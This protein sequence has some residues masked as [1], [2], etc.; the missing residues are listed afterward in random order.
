MAKLDGTK[1]VVIGGA[2]GV[3]LAVAAAALEAGAQ[4]VVGSSQAHRIAA[5][6]ETLGAGAQGHTVDVK[7]EASVAAFFEAAGPFD[8]PLRQAPA[9]GE[10]PRDRPRQTHPHDD[11]GDGAHGGHD[12]D[13]ADLFAPCALPLGH[14]LQPRAGRVHRPDQP[15]PKRDPFKR[16]PMPRLDADSGVDQLVGEDRGDLRRH[17]VGR[18]G[19]VRPDEDFKVAVRAAPVIPALADRPAPAAGAGEADGHPHPVGEGGAQR[20]EQRRH[21]GRHPVQ[22]AL[23]IVVD[24]L[25][26][27]F[28]SPQGDGLGH[29]PCRRGEQPGAR[30]AAGI[31]RGGAGAGRAAT[32]PRPGGLPLRGR[33][34]GAPL[35][36]PR[37]RSSPA[38]P[39]ASCGP[40]ARPR[41]R[42]SPDRD[43]TP[44]AARSERSGDRARS[45]RDAPRSSPQ[46][47]TIDNY[48]NAYI[49]RL[50]PNHLSP[51]VF[52][53]ILTMCWRPSQSRRGVARASPSTGCKSDGTLTTG[54][55]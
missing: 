33:G 23:P 52:S 14:A 13:L 18:V 11:A 8:H 16:T 21:A 54:S 45:L 40:Q 51:C 34:G 36:P 27:S 42:S 28:S 17:G 35:S 2:S 32:E 38:T 31:R 55:R 10:R 5:A 53:A 46:E 19:Q 4:V 7:D 37:R 15:E 22:P 43:E 26:V 3:G 41:E 6:A 20:L 1:V 25:T 44:R 39:A 49:F 30:G 47:L 12:R 24:H 29:R 48:A 50:C 9:G